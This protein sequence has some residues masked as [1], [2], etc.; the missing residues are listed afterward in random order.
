MDNLEYVLLDY[1]LF[2][3]KNADGL[4]FALSQV[5]FIL[6]PLDTGDCGCCRCRFILANH[7]LDFHIDYLFGK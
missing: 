1:V 5:R 4:H 6:C 7:L 2:H 3:L